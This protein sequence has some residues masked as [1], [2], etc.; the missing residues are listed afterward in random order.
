MFE[1]AKRIAEPLGNVDQLFLAAPPSLSRVILYYAVTTVAIVG[2]TALV[3]FTGGIAFVYAHAMYLPI[4]VAAA[5][6]GIRGGV[7]AGVLA[8]LALGPYMP[9]LVTEGL[10]QTPLNWLFRVGSFVLIGSFA[11]ALRTYLRRQLFWSAQ[12][13]RTDSGTMLPNALAF[14][15]SAEPI[16]RN[17]GDDGASVFVLAV[18]NEQDLINSFGSAI[19]DVILEELAG[20]VNER[21]SDLTHFPAVLRSR[22]L[23]FIVPAGNGEAVHAPLL[24]SLLAEPVPFEDLPVYADVSIG[25]A[26]APVHG[27]ELE[28]LISRARIAATAAQVRGSR[29]EVYH[30]GLD[31]T[32]REKLT[33]LG[34]LPGALRSGQVC[35]HYQ[36]KI[37]PKNWQ[38]CGAEAL[39]RWQHPDRGW[40]PPA[41]FINE[42]ED[43]RL[44]DQVTEWVLRE[45]VRQA[46]IWREMGFHVPVAVNISARNLL[47]PDI[48]FL[49][50]H[51]LNVENVPASG[52]ELEVTERA[53]MNDVDAGLKTMV[54]LGDLGVQLYIDDYGTGHSSLAYLRDLPVHA[55]KIDKSFI[56]TMARKP[57]DREIVASTNELCHR[58]GMKCVAEGVEDLGTLTMLGEM[59]VDYAQGFAIAEPCAPEALTELFRARGTTG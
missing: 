12:M 19:G 40:V 42:V 18:G 9:V 6:L 8:G 46:R 37:N 44:I 51:C 15:Q 32:S 43:T 35:L 39:L 48:T 5:L 50:E 4:L 1:T 29:Y 55:L 3:Y 33:L 58:L 49:V 34:E 31:R 56:G 7:F 13:A 57:R 28:E 30:E 21:L 22:E 41:A 53:L 38:I 23:S 20:R 54:G 25:I 27:E 10:M 2:I 45:S 36:P 47:R 59:S 14:R 17:A 52:L 24:R 16:L 11:G 26:K